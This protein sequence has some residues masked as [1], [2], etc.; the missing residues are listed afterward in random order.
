VIV[1]AFIFAAETSDGAFPLNFFLFIFDLMMAQIDSFLNACSLF[2]AQIVMML[3]RTPESQREDKIKGL[4]EDRGWTEEESRRSGAEF[5][6][7]R[8]FGQ[9]RRRIW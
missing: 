3:L 2:E 1:C 6:K 7:G 9:G 4:L 5:Y 8:T